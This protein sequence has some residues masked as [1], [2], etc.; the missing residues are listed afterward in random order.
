MLNATL[1]INQ[2]VAV[3][4]LW[5]ILTDLAIWL[6]QSTD[7]SKMK[8][9]NFQK[10]KIQN[11]FSCPSPNWPELDQCRPKPLIAINCTDFLTSVHHQGRRPEQEVI[12]NLKVETDVPTM[13]D[14]R[15]SGLEAA[16]TNLKLSWSQTWNSIKEASCYVARFIDS[17]GSPLGC[18]L[19]QATARF[20]FKFKFN[21]YES[22]RG[23]CSCSLQEQT[24]PNLKP[25]RVLPT[26][27]PATP[28]KKKVQ[29]TWRRPLP[30]PAACPAGFVRCLRLMPCPVT[31]CDPVSPCMA[32]QSF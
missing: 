32:G 31:A 6:E 27:P 4:T 20:K 29:P 26:G 23:C 17:L 22:E 3:K 13:P 21:S 18:C 5:C 25:E 10:M 15:D 11:E 24:P 9:Q 30:G 16:I 8:I 7:L 19:L 14:P 28:W 12:T 2:L 1:C